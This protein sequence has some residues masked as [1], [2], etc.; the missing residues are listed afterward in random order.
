MCETE[1]HIGEIGG[2]KATNR[3]E[4]VHGH[5]VPVRI[6]CKENCANDEADRQDSKEGSVNKE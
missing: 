1:E 6:Y 4:N 2:N 5:A 3:N